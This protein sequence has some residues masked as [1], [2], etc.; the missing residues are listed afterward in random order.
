MQ[1]WRHIK[2]A[3]CEHKLRKGLFE[4]T[5]CVFFLSSMLTHIFKNT[6]LPEGNEFLSK[7]LNNFLILKFHTLQLSLKV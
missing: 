4:T 6:L 7:N 1:M 3:F 5:H 2:F